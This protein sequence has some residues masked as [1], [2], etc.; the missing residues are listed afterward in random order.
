MDVF[1]DI[2]TVVLTFD[3]RYDMDVV[4]GYEID[5]FLCSSAHWVRFARMR[6]RSTGSILPTPNVGVMVV[7][8]ITFAP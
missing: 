5:R 6:M 1:V 3:S 4:L 7:F 2:F 8:L